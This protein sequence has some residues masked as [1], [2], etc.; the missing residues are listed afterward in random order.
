MAAERVIPGRAKGR[1][2]AAARIEQLAHLL[3][4]CRRIIK[5]LKRVESDDDICPLVCLRRKDAALAEPCLRGPLA[6]DLQ[7]PLLYIN[8]YDFARAAMRHLDAF[9][10]RAAT[11]IDHGF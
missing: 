11:E 2:D 3:K 7:P 1:Q 8:T 9:A 10:A 5:V 4:D 6:P